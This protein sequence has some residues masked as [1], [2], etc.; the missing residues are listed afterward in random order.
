LSA[1]I[2]IHT[3]LDPQVEVEVIKNAYASSEA[4]QLSST[5]RG[6]ED[7]VKHT[8]RAYIDKLKHAPHELEKEVEKAEQTIRKDAKDV[9]HKAK[10]VLSLQP[11][12]DEEDE[13]WSSDHSDNR[14]PTGSTST[15]VGR[16]KRSR[17]PTSKVQ[18]KAVGAPQRKSRRRNSVR[19]G[20]LGRVDLL[21]QKQREHPFVFDDSDGEGDDHR[22]RSR[23]AVTKTEDELT[24][25]GSARN[26]RL[27]AIRR[28]DARR[29]ESPTR[30]IRFADE[31]EVEDEEH[32]SG[33]TT[34]QI[35]I[36]QESSPGS[37]L[38]LSSDDADS[39]KNKVT[40]DVANN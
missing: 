7:S 29:E 32:R 1:H 11:G 8:L 30:S 22:G 40:F 37:P 20:M 27:D 15:S 33:T 18:P 10:D 34:P 2:Q 4:E 35:S 3:D 13:G 19:K 21:K 14:Q 24:H 28:I 9:E 16:R 23:A 17:S 39:P 12:H 26:L 38:Q 25:L 36:L 31:V 6:T 5:F